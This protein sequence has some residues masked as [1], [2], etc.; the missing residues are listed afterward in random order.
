MD[1]H[2]VYSLCLYLNG[3]RHLLPVD[4][5]Q[6]TKWEKQNSLYK[7]LITSLNLIEELTG[8]R[9]HHYYIQSKNV[10]E[11]YLVH[12]SNATA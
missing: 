12:L 9:E 4:V 11:S 8:F 1:V 10:I 3:K 2:L 7:T 6:T 5:K